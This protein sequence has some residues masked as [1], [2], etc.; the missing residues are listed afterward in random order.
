M[1]WR[2]GYEADILSSEDECELAESEEMH[3]N[4][5][6]PAMT[7]GRLAGVVRTWVNH[8]D[9]LIGGVDSSYVQNREQI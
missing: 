5:H 3:M 4:L 1:T 6:E 9:C 2:E 8:V 7:G